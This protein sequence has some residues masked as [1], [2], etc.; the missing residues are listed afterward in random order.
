MGQS[1]R[2]TDE[3]L[4]MLM[5]G[6]NHYGNVYADLGSPKAKHYRRLRDRL[7]SYKQE[8]ADWFADR[9]KFTEQLNNLSFSP[10]DHP[11]WDGDCEVGD[12]TN[13]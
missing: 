12:F 6:C 4:S 9:A 1:L 13:G 7:R 8:R 3:E 5:A 2:F 11:G 10:T